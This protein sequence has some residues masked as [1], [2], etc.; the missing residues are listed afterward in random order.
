MTLVETLLSKLAEIGTPSHPGVF[1]ADA[2]PG[3]AAVTL[4]YQRCDD[5]SVQLDSIDV[6]GVAVGPLA[7]WA[8]RVSAN[9][10]RLGEP[11][12]LVEADAGSGQAIARSPEPVSWRGYRAYYEV[13]FKAAEGALEL[14]RYRVSEGEAAAKREAVPFVLTH[15]QLGRLVAGLVGA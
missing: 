2:G 10:S 12:R 4:Q 14:K 7:E 9:A 13:L 3:G 8:N 1:K 5:L 6:R 15:E 11:L